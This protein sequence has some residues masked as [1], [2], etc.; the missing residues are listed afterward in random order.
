LTGGTRQ[1]NSVVGFDGM[2]HAGVDEQRL[3]LEK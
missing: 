1:Q 3:G 2:G